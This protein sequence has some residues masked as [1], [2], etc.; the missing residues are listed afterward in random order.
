MSLFDKDSII[1][2]YRKIK[3]KSIYI[4]GQIGKIKEKLLNTL[5]PVDILLIIA[6]L[7][8]IITPLIVNLSFRAGSKS[9]QVN[10]YLSQNCEKLFGKEVTET[11]FREFGERNPDLKLHLLNASASAPDAKGKVVSADILFFDDE[12]FSS[13]VAEGSL[14]ELNAFTNYE[15]GSTQFA[16]PLVSFM[17][18]LFYNIN[19]LSSAGF[20]RPP[21]TREEF[22]AY[23]KS[24]S[25][26]NFPGVS[27]TAVSLSRNDH[28][29]LSRDIFS[30]IWA[31][32]GDF[33]ADEEGPVLN[34]RAITSDIGFLG[35]LNSEG[36]FA[37]KIF[38]TTGEQ[39]LEQFSQGKIA[40]M[41]A[42]TRD[43]PYLRKKMGDEAFGITTIPV[44]ASNGKYGIG[45]SAIYAGISINAVHPDKAWSFLEFLVEKLP[46]LCTEL[47]AVPGAVSQLIPGDYVKEDPFY[48]KA[49]DIFESSKIVQGFSGKAG[50]KE[51]E[52]SFLLGLRSFLEGGA[53]VQE[54]ASTI[55]ML[56]DGVE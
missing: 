37:S 56:W 4:G 40:M 35:S 19:I 47:K 11:L 49:W 43:I 13:L 24:V 50:A 28:H 33:W 36:V 29:S 17:D 5:E 38:D 1:N 6:I 18:L 39:R 51:Y 45:L 42:S 46:L 2:F 9:K 7:L 12:D 27:G 54:T 10:L 23:A 34:T 15:S 55:Q 44:S 26:G 30:W 25:G 52:V 53:T 8:L 3:E 48:S 32:G 41:V 14:M 22:T 20:T 16:I 31:S 21:K